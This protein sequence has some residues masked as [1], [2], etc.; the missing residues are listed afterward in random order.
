MRNRQ[1]ITSDL[2]EIDERCQI[3]ARVTADR[4]H[5]ME[6]AI[7][8]AMKLYGGYEPE[9]NKEDL[10][11][12]PPLTRDQISDAW[13]I[14]RAWRSPLLILPHK[15]ILQLWYFVACRDERLAARALHTHVRE[16][17]PRLRAALISINNIAARMK[18]RCLDNN[19]KTC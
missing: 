5:P 12:L 4:P 14:D 16:I 19:E 1:V 7:Y 13:L 2:V 17:V 11:S 8:R 6:T 3:W 9:K 18:R 10:E 15:N